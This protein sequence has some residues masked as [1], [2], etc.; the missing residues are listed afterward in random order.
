MSDHLPPLPDDPRI[1]VVIPVRDAA[2]TLAAAVDAVLDQR[3]A[4]AEV[5][6]AVSPSLDESWEVAER[7]RASDP[8]VIRLVD[9]PVGTTPAGLNAAIAA[10]T[11]QV[12]ARVDAHAVLPP[13]YLASAVQALRATGAGNVGGRQVPF[14]EDGFARAV[15][16]A[17]R[18]PAGSGGAAYRGA[19]EPGEVDTVYLGVFRREALEAVG[20]YDERFLRNQD[21]ELNLRLA[22][23]GYPVWYEPALEVSYRPRGSVAALARQYLGYGRW[24]RQTARTH[25]GTLQARQLAAPALV[26]GLAGAAACS[27]LTRDRRPFATA[28][29][30]YAAGVLAAG[31]QAVDEPGA[32]PATGLAL[33]TMHLS[34]GVGFLL[35]PPGDAVE[36]SAS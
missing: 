31:A 15:A 7:L 20:G 17:M 35:G 23:A 26:L 22:A 14:A 2:G 5:V 3:P 32:A 29:G 9:N 12:I 24:R 1:S 21:A 11:G 13:G 34:W 8:D 28:A 18:S 6:L 33:A 25:P 4:A 16:A 36:R 27:L 19:R 30:A 10:S